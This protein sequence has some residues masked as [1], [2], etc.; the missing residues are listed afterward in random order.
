[1]ASEEH[2]A[3]FEKALPSL[4]ERF[5]NDLDIVAASSLDL[6]D[7]WDFKEDELL[8]VIGKKGTKDSDE[9]Y[10]ELLDLVR[11]NPLNAKPVPK[12]FNRYMRPLII[13]KL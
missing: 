3:Y 6:V 11:L 13:G 10:K 9:M 7:G 1:M 12:G 5:Y 2:L 8:S 4:K